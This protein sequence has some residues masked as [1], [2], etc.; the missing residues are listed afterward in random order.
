MRFESWEDA[1]KKAK[2]KTTD[3]FPVVVSS[4]DPLQSAFRSARSGLVWRA[5]AIGV[6]ILVAFVLGFLASSFRSVGSGVRP[7]VGV[8]SSST[9]PDPG[10]I[11]RAVSSPPYSILKFDGDRD[12]PLR[13]DIYFVRLRE[14]V[15]KDV[16]GGLAD[17]IRRI[18]PPG[19]ER[20][21]IWFYLPQV[22]AFKEGGPFGAPWA[23]ADFDPG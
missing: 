3:G 21:V 19:K 9:A 6:F 4:P 8:Q 17:E 16:L 20:T 10:G 7:A 18:G 23:L 13:K 1:V 11:A 14:K 2:P 12:N 22:D 5:S 15:T